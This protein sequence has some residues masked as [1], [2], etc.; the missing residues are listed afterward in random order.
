MKHRPE[1]AYRKGKD[2]GSEAVDW[3]AAKRVG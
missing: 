3:N 2:A 1:V